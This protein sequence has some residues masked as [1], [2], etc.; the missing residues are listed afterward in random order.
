MKVLVEFVGK[1]AKEANISKYWAFLDEA[2]TLGDFFNA[3]ERDKGIKINPQKMNIVVLV[4]GH[5][6]NFP[7]DL[8]I[9][10]KELDKIVIMYPV[11]GG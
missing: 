7:E 2:T 4:N 8:N 5:S 3:L 11:A 9:K 1:L 6:A 10:L